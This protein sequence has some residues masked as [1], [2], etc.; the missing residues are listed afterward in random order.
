MRGFASFAGDV[1]SVHPA[2]G[3][4]PPLQAAP[5]ARPSPPHPA[6]LCAPAHAPTRF[7]CR[8]HRRPRTSAGGASTLRTS[9][10]RPWTRR[11][12]PWCTTRRALR[13]T[14]RAGP[15]SSRRAGPS[16]RACRV[17][18]SPCL[19]SFLSSVVDFLLAC[20]KRLPPLRWRPLF[21]SGAAT[22]ICCFCYFCCFPRR[23]GW[24]GPSWSSAR[25][26]AC[27][28]TAPLFAPS[29]SSLADAAG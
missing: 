3:S 7:P 10:R 1:G 21:S 11:G 26:C 22:G 15:E 12:C 29:R 19:P 16:L 9:I 25:Q 2:P 5:A 6:P 28:A 24:A 20:G 14:G 13:P 4:P 8:Q 17:S 27:R 23:Q 18:P